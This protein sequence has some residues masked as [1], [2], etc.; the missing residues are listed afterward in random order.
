[1]FPCYI[2]TILYSRDLSQHFS[3]EKNQP[4]EEQIIGPQIKEYVESL[5][6]TPFLPHSSPFHSTAVPLKITEIRK[7]S[8]LKGGQTSS[9]GVGR[10]GSQAGR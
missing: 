2:L 7:R 8:N 3:E 10:E 4:Q 1:M 5:D 9:Q 6:S